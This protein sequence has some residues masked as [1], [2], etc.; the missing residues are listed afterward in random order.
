M[1]FAQSNM[2]EFLYTPG[3]FFEIPEF[4]RP[5]SWQTSNVEEFLSD[6]EECIAKGKNH[7]FGTV[8]QVKDTGKA[9]SRAIID[10]QQRV[11]TSMLMISAIY[12]LAKKNPLLIE[13]PE[14][15]VEKIEYQISA[16]L[17]SMEV[18]TRC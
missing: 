1:I 15:S 17:M 6:L 11:T 7:Y 9:Y 4:Q 16:E 5:Y 8:V 12:H 13:D 2:K 18:V 10:G 3:M 14:T